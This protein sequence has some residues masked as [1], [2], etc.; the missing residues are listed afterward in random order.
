MH[1]RVVRIVSENF[2]E[3]FVDQFEQLRGWEVEIDGNAK[4]L[5][6]APVG[7]TVVDRKKGW[8]MRTYIEQVRD[9]VVAH[10]ISPVM[11]LTCL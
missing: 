4:V 1:F 2:A 10:S 11:F 6:L 5:E 7:G 8:V 3:M 9:Y